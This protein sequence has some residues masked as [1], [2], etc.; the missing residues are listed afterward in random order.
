M[1]S[2]IAKHVKQFFKLCTPTRHFTA[3]HPGISDDPSTKM[4]ALHL[5]RMYEMVTLALKNYSIQVNWYV[6][7]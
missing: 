6:G 3:R 7:V 5:F 4:N 1:V 2:L